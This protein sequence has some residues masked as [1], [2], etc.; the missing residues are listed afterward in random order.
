MTNKYKIK[1]G[2]TVQVISGK[3]R[4]KRGTV[5]KIHVD[6]R[7]VTVNS[8]NLVTRNV[9]PDYKHPQGPFRKEMPIDI[10][11]VALIDPSTNNIGKIGWK[12]DDAGKKVR[13]FKKSGATL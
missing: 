11:N 6:D 2:D 10:S 12:I 3:E 5:K 4:G 8:I 7:K 9:K 1:R 13:F